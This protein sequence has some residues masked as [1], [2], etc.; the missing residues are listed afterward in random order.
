MLSGGFRTSY[1]WCDRN[2]RNPVRDRVIRHLL[3]THPP[4]PLHLLSLPGLGWVAERRLRRRADREVRVTGLE[5]LPEVYAEVEST[6][7][8]WAELIL[9]TSS[10]YLAG[11]PD[12]EFSAVWLDF[13]SNLNDEVF[14]TV[15]R[16]PRWL[17]KGAAV[18][19][20]F[21][22]LANREKSTE[23]LERV[24]RAAPGSAVARRAEVLIDAVRAHRA[25]TGVTQYFSYRITSLIGVVMGVYAPVTH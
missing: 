18:P 4:G 23:T 8:G 16:L 24:G 6:R 10:E 22:F 9:E 17:S 19:F 12:R 3:A 20:A 25:L 1:Y 5:R 15:R 11:I 13:T 2:Y 21:T 7:P 14:D